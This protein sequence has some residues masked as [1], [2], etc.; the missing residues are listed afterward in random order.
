MGGGQRK[1]IYVRTGNYYKNTPRGMLFG[2]LMSPFS[3]YQFIRLKVKT[4]PF[5]ACKSELQFSR[6]LVKQPP[7]HC[8][9][10]MRACRLPTTLIILLLLESEPGFDAV[11]FVVRSRFRFGAVRQLF[12][13][14]QTPD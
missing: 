11:P 4:L 7:V 12:I 1:T 9:S 2:F 6:N 14:R 10:F 8:A 5:L 13:V 3:C